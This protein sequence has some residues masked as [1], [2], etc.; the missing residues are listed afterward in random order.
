VASVFADRRSGLCRW[1][2]T[3]LVLDGLAPPLTCVAV[4]RGAKLEGKPKDSC[5]IRGLRARGRPDG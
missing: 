3:R 2:S 4:R 1:R 5:S